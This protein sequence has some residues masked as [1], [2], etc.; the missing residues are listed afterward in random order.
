[1]YNSWLFQVCKL[2]LSL[3]NLGFKAC[4]HHH[5][6]RRVRHTG[7]EC[8]Q[9][10]LRRSEATRA[11]VAGANALCDDRW[12]VVGMEAGPL[13]LPEPEQAPT[14]KLEYAS[15]FCLVQQ[16]TSHHKTSKITDVIIGQMMT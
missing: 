8:R 16:T 14:F 15:G 2:S 9:Q 11:A 5:R 7:F 13:L 6:S 1:M 12:R 3:I 4:F 10:I